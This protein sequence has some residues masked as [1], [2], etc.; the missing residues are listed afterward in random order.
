MGSMRPY[1]A[2]YLGPAAVLLA[3]AV[4]AIGDGSAQAV[5][6]R[7]TV[8]HAGRAPGTGA[9]GNSADCAVS[10]QR[11]YS[12][13]LG[14]GITMSADVPGNAGI[15]G[16]VGTQVSLHKASG[17]WPDGDFTVTPVAQ[18]FQ[19][20]GFDSHD[21]YSAYSYLCHKDAALWVYE[22]QW[23]PLGNDSGLCAGVAVGGRAGEKVTL[24]PCGTDARTLWIA[25]QGH[26][27]G[28]ACAGPGNF[29]P[30]ISGADSHFR[31]PLVLT[32]DD[33]GQPAAPPLLIGTEQLAPG[34][35]H[36][37]ENLQQF[38]H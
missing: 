9:A 30:W 23:S 11:V 2:G 25:D 7:T 22:A 4:V 32:V 10:C 29:C 28:A 19:F 38:A 5:S 13:R 37:A 8:S 15:G 14:A 33:R 31:H 27:T 12:Q 17:N 6:V 20:C 26:G 34:S 21:F 18:V 1:L 16:N 24:Q 35:R 36:R 3:A